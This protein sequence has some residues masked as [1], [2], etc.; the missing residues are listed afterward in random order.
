MLKATGRLVCLAI[1]QMEEAA[2]ERGKVEGLT[3]L[4]CHLKT[5]NSNLKKQREETEPNARGETSYAGILGTATPNPETNHEA[6][7]KPTPDRQGP[8]QHGRTTTGQ[9][10]DQHRS[11]RGPHHQT[12]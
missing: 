2:F 1:R 12:E 4:I 11:H 9:T 3:K 5:E 10:G 8:R 7:S 6:E